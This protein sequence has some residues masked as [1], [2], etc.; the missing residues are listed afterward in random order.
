MHLE[1]EKAIKESLLK[2]N[3]QLLI[4]RIMNLDSLIKDLKQSNHSIKM[5]IDL[6]HSQV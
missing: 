1:K 4:D 2:V 5:H 6:K 3:N